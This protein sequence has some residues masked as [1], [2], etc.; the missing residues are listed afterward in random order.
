[1]TK[2]NSDAPVLCEVDGRGVAQV[3]LNRP[4]RNNAYDGALITALHA[5][6]D[7]LE[8]TSGLRAVV[9]SG[10]G[11]HF[12]AGADLTWIN[13]IRAASREDNIAASRA[14]AQAI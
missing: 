4:E 9:I 7:A 1:M 10:R 8:K 11:R 12:Q 2:P 5:T 14:T 13:A 3:A 6:L